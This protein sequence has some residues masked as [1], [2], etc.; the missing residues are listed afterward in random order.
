MLA[1]LVRGLQPRHAAL[2]ALPPVP[3]QG[4]NL[5]ILP[6]TAST[7]HQREEVEAAEPPRIRDAAEPRHEDNF[8]GF[9]EVPHHLIFI[10]FVGDNTT[11]RINFLDLFWG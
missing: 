6:V 10:E 4:V 9:L 8:S 5:P 1:L 11:D 7:L 3:K 2:E